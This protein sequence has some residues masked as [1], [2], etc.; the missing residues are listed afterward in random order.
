M[1]KI[2]V[3]TG[4]RAEY[5][6]L[7]GVIAGLA[8]SDEFELQLLV[9][10]M[11]LANEFGN[12]WQEIVND[13]F[14]ITHKV[15]MLLSSDTP[16]AISKSVGLGLLGFSDAFNVLKPDLILVLGDRFEIYAAVTCAQIH[17]VPVAHLHGGELT[18][19]LIDNA[20]RHSI[21]KMSHL[22]F[23]AAEEYYLRLVKMGEQ[24]GSVFNVGG[25]GVDAIK[26]C[27]RMPQ[28]ALESSMAFKFQNQN[29]LV[30]FHPVTLEADS[31]KMQMESLLSALDC[32]PD[33]GVIFT[34]PNADTE[35]R[36]AFQQISDYVAK[37]DNASAYP[38]LG[39]M[40]Y[41]SCMS[42]VDAVVGNSSSGLL[43]AP[44]LR[45]PTV[46]IGDRQKGR[47]KA[48]T[49]IDCPPTRND[50]CDAINEC[51]SPD[52][53][54]V[55][56]TVD[57]PYGDGGASSKIIEILEQTSFDGLLKKTFYDGV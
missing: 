41:I 14:Q 4:T 17:R 49:V 10:G 32:F 9:T 24:P 51:L 18:E 8:E 53:A 35:S 48:K 23:V 12:T 6:L 55:C 31:M 50:I 45:K 25:L 39:F 21:S 16:S 38:S 57:S 19:G 5:G 20:F 33:F 46:N 42:L 11:H 28:V 7:K 26:N 3:I 15:E 1:K 30:T 54:Q 13:G 43:E 56:A 34:L 52:M 36:I 22:H 27:E 29:L 47:L 37:R 40:R 44:T 2:C